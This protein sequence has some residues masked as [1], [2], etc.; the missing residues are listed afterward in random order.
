MSSPDGPDI[1]QGNPWW[2]WVI[3]G[4]G[5]PSDYVADRDRLRGQPA[6]PGVVHLPRPT[7]AEPVA[8]HRGNALMPAVR[9][10]AHADERPVWARPW[11]LGFGIGG[12]LPR[13]WLDVEASVLTT[14]RSRQNRALGSTPQRP[15]HSSVRSRDPRRWSQWVSATLPDFEEVAMARGY[16]RLGLTGRLVWQRSVGLLGGVVCG[17]AAEAS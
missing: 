10:H 2:W 7:T 13:P 17:Q 12:G 3:P 9:S 4:A 11:R 15:T 6:R 5:D 14:P 1:D 16:L 8:I